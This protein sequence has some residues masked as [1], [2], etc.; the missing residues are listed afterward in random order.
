MARI[1]WTC[2]F[3]FSKDFSIFRLL[4]AKAFQENKIILFLTKKNQMKIYAAVLWTWDF[5]RFKFEILFLD[6]DRWMHQFEDYV[7]KSRSSSAARE[8]S[9]STAIFL[10]SRRSPIQLIKSILFF[11]SVLVKRATA[12]KK[13]LQISHQKLFARFLIFFFL[14][15]KNLLFFRSRF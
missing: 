3:A 1:F 12:K 6:C 9:K 7:K 5:F 15:C 8:N 11:I 10:F 14:W 13:H 2:Y 4:F